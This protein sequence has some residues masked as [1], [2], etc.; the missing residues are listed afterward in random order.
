MRLWGWKE[1]EGLQP[2]HEDG[3]DG[4]DGVHSVLGL[5]EDDGLRAFEH[6]VGDLH[7]GD[8]ELFADLAADG[9]VEV[10]EGRQAVH[11]HG[12]V[13]RSLHQLVVDLIGEQIRNALGPDL[14]R[15]AH[16]HPHVGID[17]VGAPDG[18]GGL[19]A[20]IDGGAGLG[21]DGLGWPRRS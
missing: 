3:H 8:A 20:E 13:A 15:L 12:V 10:V 11:Q 18:F 7:L 9:G 2:C 16:G 19:G 14:V 1:K 21:G 4:L 17:D 5:I 6:L